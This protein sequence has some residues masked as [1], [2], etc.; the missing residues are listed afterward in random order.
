MWSSRTILLFIWWFQRTLAYLINYL[1]LLFLHIWEI[2]VWISWSRFFILFYLLV[3]FFLFSLIRLLALI[4]FIVFE[5]RVRCEGDFWA[6]E[7]CLALYSKT[8]LICSVMVLE[9]LCFFSTFCDF[10]SLKRYNFSAFFRLKLIRA[11]LSIWEAFYISL[12][13][14]TVGLLLTECRHGFWLLVWLF[15]LLLFYSMAAWGRTFIFRRYS[16]GVMLL[17]S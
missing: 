9:L 1:L 16:D 4:F 17:C 6:L 12:F 8:F 10:F 15:V 11:V 14:L 13:D 7:S 2:Q 3:Y 5:G